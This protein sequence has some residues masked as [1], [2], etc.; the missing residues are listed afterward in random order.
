MSGTAGTGGS[1]G[2]TDGTVNSDNTNDAAANTGGGGG[3]AGSSG[4]AH[5]GANGGSGVVILRYPND[6]TI[7]VGA[8]LTAG[9]ETADGSAKYIVIT[10]GTGNV[11]WA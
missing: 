5:A 9:S 7:T 10:A 3:G 11:S 6:K 8:G 2:G 1:G 4:P